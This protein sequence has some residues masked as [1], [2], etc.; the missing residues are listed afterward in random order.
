MD[1]ANKNRVSVRIS[2]DVFFELERYLL[3]RQE[4]LGIR[5]TKREF[6]DA[7]I[8]ERLTKSL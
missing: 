1:R 8:K 5:E 2:K 7:A 6:I 4:R 3:K